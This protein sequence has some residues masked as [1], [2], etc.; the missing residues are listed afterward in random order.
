MPDRREF[1]VGALGVGALGAAEWLRPRRA[2][3]LFGS[4]DLTGSVPLRF[5]RWNEHDGGNV[6][7]PVTPNSLA[8]RLYSATL[9]RIYI[10]QGSSDPPVMLLVAYGGEQSDLLQLHRPE[11]CYPAVGLEILDRNL[12]AMPLGSGIEPLPVTMLSAGNPDRQ[13]DIVYW[14]RLGE[15]FPRS[16]SEQR[17]SRL[18]AAMA[19][20]IG[21]GMLVRASCIGS[22]GTSETWPYLQDFLRAMIAGI[23]PN[24]RKGFVGTERAA[25]LA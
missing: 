23:A 14:T 15:A 5:G 12:G 6:I 25:E 17:S 24:L 13:E 7:A 3:R 22:G 20:V 8:D 19:G 9:T 1:M 11:T 2:I 4:S 10:S 21:D 18:K 16:G